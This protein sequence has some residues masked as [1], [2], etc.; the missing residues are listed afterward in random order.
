MPEFNLLR[1]YPKTKRDIGARKQAQATAREIAKRYGREY[2]D[3]T[4][5]E[6]Y[7][8]YRYDGRWVPIAK[9]IIDHYGLKSG[10]RVLDVGCAKGFLVKDLMDA[11]PGLEVWGLD[12]SEYAIAQSHPDIAGRLVRG[13]AD[14]L[15]FADRSFQAVLCIN[16]IHNLEREACLRAIR[17]VERLAPGRAY[18]QVDAY[19]DETE[20]DIFLDW[21][22]T[23]V[24]YGPPEFW[25]EMFAEAGYTGDYYWTIITADPEWTVLDQGTKAEGRRNG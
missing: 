25:R 23:A 4:R 3:G 1:L 19:R 20:R 5:D 18:I 13:T 22:L 7:G 17:E 16:V 6:G 15:P 9:Q 12:I 21:V 14:R 8:G 2:F 24:T 11:C 10:D